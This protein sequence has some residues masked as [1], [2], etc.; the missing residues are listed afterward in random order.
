M[1]ARWEDSGD[2]ILW[3]HD[4]QCTEE[5]CVKA[6][7]VEWA[8]SGQADHAVLLSPVH[9]CSLVLDA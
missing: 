3:E 6:L 1:A 7:L 2:R 4:A 8:L 9:R 5:G